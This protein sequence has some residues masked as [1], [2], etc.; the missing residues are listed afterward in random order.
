MDK[1]FDMQLT[2]RFLKMYQKTDKKGKS[3][4]F[5]QDWIHFHVDFRLGN[6]IP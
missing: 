4:M 1:E 2:M 6:L 3:E 5:S